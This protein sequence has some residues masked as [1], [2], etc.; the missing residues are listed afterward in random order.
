MRSAGNFHPEWG[1]FAP[2]PRF[3]RTVRIAVVAAAIGASAGAVV[4]ISL[5]SPSRTNLNNRSGPAYALISASSAVASPAEAV[6]NATLAARDTASP[7]LA[8]LSSDIGGAIAPVAAVA[9]MR[10]PPTAANPEPDAA[11]ARKRAVR[12]HRA[13]LASNALKYARDERALT[14]PYQLPRHSRYVQLDRSCCAWTPPTAHNGS[15]W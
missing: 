2:L 12:L 7:A 8:S 1:Y 9:M 5:L 15:G 14:R 3:R 13:R 6:T 10:S 4:G 11:W